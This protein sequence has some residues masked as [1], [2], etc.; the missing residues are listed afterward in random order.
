MSMNEA[1]TRY[2]LIDPVLRKKGY[3]SRDQITLETILTPAPVDPTG[4]KGSR[5]KGSGRT[6]Y[7]LCVQVGDMPK[8]LPV[9]V[10]EAKKESEDTL[11]GMQQAMG[12]ADCQRFEVKYVFA[13]NGHRYGEYDFITRLQNGP[14]PFADFPPHP[15]LTARYA[16][17]T[18][19]DLAHPEAA[20]LFQ[21]DSPAWAQSRY[22][23][24]AAI[25]A[26]FE[27]LLQ[28]RMK[29]EPAPPRRSLITSPPREK[30]FP[31]HWPN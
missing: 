29:G 18:G 20:I 11:K 10:L 30:L 25:R 14:F 15:D 13:T 19:I 7:L 1:D 17:D 2:H 21:V 26:S 5:R 12:Y 16:K 31:E 6:E 27:K 23:Q 9:A 3:V 24:D 28:C 22:Y 8:P 4:P